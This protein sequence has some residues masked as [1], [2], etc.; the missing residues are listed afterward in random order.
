LSRMRGNLLVRFL[1]EGV[2]ARLPPY[3]VKKCFEVRE[4]RLEGERRGVWRGGG[5]GLGLGLDGGTGLGKHGGT[6]VHGA[7]RETVV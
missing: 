2:A 5:G 1:G 7:R 6:E 4:M 3:P